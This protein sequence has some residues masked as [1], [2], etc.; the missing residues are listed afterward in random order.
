[1]CKITILQYP[2]CGCDARDGND[3]DGFIVT[4]RWHNRLL[5]DHAF[6]PFE[7]CLQAKYFALSKSKSHTAEFSRCADVQVKNIRFEEEVCFRCLM[8]QRSKERAATIRALLAEHRSFSARYAATKEPATEDAES[9][10]RIWQSIRAPRQLE[11]EW[12]TKRQGLIGTAKDLGVKQFTSVREMAANWEDR[13]KSQLDSRER[14]SEK[15]VEHRVEATSSDSKTHEKRKQARLA[16]LQLHLAHANSQILCLESEEDASP[17]LDKEEKEQDLYTQRLPVRRLRIVRPE[18]RSSSKTR[19]TAMVSTQAV[20]GADIPRAPL[21]LM[22]TSPQ[23]VCVPKS[24][25]TSRPIVKSAP[26]KDSTVLSVE[27]P[28]FK[29]FRQPPPTEPQLMRAPTAPRAMREGAYSSLPRTAG[30]SRQRFAAVHGY[31][32]IRRWRQ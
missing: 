3:G 19:A 32:T 13:L 8:D 23:D 29:P 22:K 14:K 10:G 9:N 25:A 7:R 24:D 17:A 18:K 6:V 28:N 20:Q 31:A 4:K 16:Y 27:A 15:R 2:R 5:L 30:R 26:S 11:T 21:A 1:M 12:K